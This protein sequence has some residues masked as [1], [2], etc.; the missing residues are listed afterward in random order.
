[1]PAP[2]DLAIAT[3]AVERLVK[4]EAFYRAELAKQ[5]ERV[6][7]LAAEIAAANDP[8]TLDGNAEFVLKQ[9]SRAVDETKAVFAPLKQR[10]AEAVST[11]EQQ[12]AIREADAADAQTDGAAV[13]DELDKARAVL[14][15]GQTAVAKEI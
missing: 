8:S 7:Q 10:T 3:K 11:L 4:E 5:Q 15:T 2:S 14:R 1:M 13:D 6:R 12:I 9:E